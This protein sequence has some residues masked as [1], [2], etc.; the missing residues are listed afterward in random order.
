MTAIRGPCASCPWRVDAHGGI[1]GFSME[2]AEGLV[3]TT[4]TG[5]GAPMF[6][7]HQSV[8]GEEV[9]CVG[10]LARYGW[11]SIAVR[12]GLADGRFTA[13][14]LN[15]AE[16][17]DWPETHETFAEVIEKLRADYTEQREFTRKDDFSG[18]AK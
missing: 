6:G 14:Q 12:F 2:M 8:E 7:C 17:D 1:P 11:D 18:G 9:V 13:D 4:A 15:A 16:L 5:L 3:T 10:W